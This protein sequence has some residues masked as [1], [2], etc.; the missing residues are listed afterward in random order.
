MAETESCSD[1]QGLC[2]LYVPSVFGERAGTELNI[3][4]VF[5]QAVFAAIMVGER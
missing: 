3:G 2:C 1:R 4:Q 5:P